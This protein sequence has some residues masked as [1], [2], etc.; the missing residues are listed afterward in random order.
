MPNYS[1]PNKSKLMLLIRILL[2]QGDQGYK[3]PNQSLLFTARK[4]KGTQTQK[5]RKDI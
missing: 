5:N 1:L 3:V 4:I 2:H